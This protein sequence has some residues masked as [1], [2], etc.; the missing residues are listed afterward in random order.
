M[1]NKHKEVCRAAV[2]GGVPKSTTVFDLAGTFHEEV[3]KYL[4]CPP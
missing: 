1:M 4:A 3:A 2:Y